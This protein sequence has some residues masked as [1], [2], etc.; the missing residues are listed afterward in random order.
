[1][2]RRRVESEVESLVLA[3]AFIIA[4]HGQST[5]RGAVRQCVCSAPEPDS[6]RVFRRLLS[7]GCGVALLLLGRQPYIDI[8]P[9]FFYFFC[10]PDDRKLGG[11]SAR[12]LGP[13]PTYL[14]RG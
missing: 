7:F 4:P 2:Q 3:G 9:S 6:A 13:P 11:R 5:S 14:P 12:A 10:G 1:M 8:L